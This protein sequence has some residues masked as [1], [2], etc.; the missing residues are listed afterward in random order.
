MSTDWY[1]NAA[2][3]TKCLICQR[4]YVYGDSL[5]LVENVVVQ[6]GGSRPY[7]EKNDLL[8]D[9]DIELQFTRFAAALPVIIAKR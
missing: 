5:S 6:V 3:A 1:N 9:I 2:L 7:N 8:T 4:E